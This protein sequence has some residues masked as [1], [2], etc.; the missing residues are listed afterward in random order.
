[1]KNYFAKLT[2]KT[3]LMLVIMMTCTILLAVISSTLLIAEFYASR[4]SLSLE[5]KTIASTLAANIGRSLV[6][7]KYAEV[8]AILSSLK[9]QKNIHAAYVFNRS[10]APVAE[11]L[12]QQDP[13]FVLTAI[14]ND[15]QLVNEPYW[16]DGSEHSLITLTHFSFFLPL[17]FDGETI[18]SIYL[19]TDLNSLYGRVN[20][21]IFGILLALLLLLGCSWLLAGYLQKPVSTPL[22]KLATVMEQVAASQ[23]YS[24]RAEKITG[25]EVGLLADGFNRML[26]KIERQQDKLIRHHRQLEKTVAERTAELRVTVAELKQARHQAD[27]AN[28]AKSDFLSKMTHE[29]RTPLIGVL[30]MNEL[31]QRTPLDEQQ[32]MLVDTVQKSGEELLH[33]ISDVLDLSRIEA[34]KLFLEPEAVHLYQILEEVVHLLHPLAQQKGLSLTVDIPLSATWKV[35][36]DESRIRQILMNLISNAIKFTSSGSVTVSLS[37]TQQTANEGLFKF[38]VTD[39]GMGINEE[40]KNQIFDIFYQADSGGTREKN[41]AGLGLAIVKQL[42]DL[43]NGELTLTSIPGQGSCFQVATVFP[44]VERLPFELPDVLHSQS[45]LLCVNE[46]LSETLLKERLNELSFT[47]DLASNGED[48]LDKL[49]SAL[50]AEKPYKFIFLGLGVDVSTGQPLYRLLREEKALQSLRTI[51]VT[52]DQSAM[53]DLRATE[54]KLHLPLSWSGLQSALTRSWQNLHLVTRTPGSQQYEQDES[55]LATQPLL[56]LLGHHVASRELLRLA[57]LKHP[58]DIVAAGNV[59]DLEKVLETN[60]CSGLFI[61]YPY[62][63]ESELLLFLK[64]HFQ[65]LPVVFLFS[66]TSLSDD[67]L[68]FGY[69]CLNKPPNGDEFE[70]KL[71][72]ILLPYLNSG[73]RNR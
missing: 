52:S 31:M 63:P 46:P 47:V 73:V 18:G 64:K 28:E 43:M 57:L 70:A 36:V 33:L 35:Y 67:L 14:K 9:Q 8:E 58:I 23:D 69:P 48:A 7:G 38:R 50:R 3:K 60:S 37:Y 61:D 55:I 56:M 24:V 68:A 32:K 1:M 12:N 51:L 54:T 6:L 53:I 29:L 62:L 26:E 41:G 25:D 71:K 10:G 30:G 39:T 22:I 72:P 49:F 27:A 17:D 13:Q 5:I 2:I 40:E 45:V 44:L 34:G 4:A 11:F 66:D 59:Q 16:K 65:E 20:G 15:F 19:L 42:V 21:V